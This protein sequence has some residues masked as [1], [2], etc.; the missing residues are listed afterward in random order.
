MSLAS[1]AL[2]W[3]VRVRSYSSDSSRCALGVAG[4]VWVPLVPIGAPWL[5]L[6][7][8]GF[9]WFVQMCPGYR[10]FVWMRRGSRSDSSGSSRCAFGVSALVRFILVRTCT[11]WGSLGSFGF[12]WFLRVRPG[13]H[14]VCLGSS[15]WF[16]SRVRVSGSF[17]SCGWALEVVGF[18]GVRLVRRGAPLRSLDSSGFVRV[19]YGGR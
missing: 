13:G 9:I 1:F 14:L 7:S 18:D 5:S 19:R 10:W 8:F 2:V 4:L 3:F 12:I 16:G 11:P 15:A 6:S 17:G